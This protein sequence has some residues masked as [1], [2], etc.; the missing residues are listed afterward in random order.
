M[1]NGVAGNLAKAPNRPGPQLAVLLPAL[2]LFD[3]ETFKAGM[4]PLSMQLT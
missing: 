2:F 4:H 3:W 1:A